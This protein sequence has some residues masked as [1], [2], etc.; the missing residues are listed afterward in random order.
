MKP[1]FLQQ[2]EIG[3][4]LTPFIDV[5]FL[6]I[7]FF[8]LVFQF[9]AAEL[10]EVRLPEKIASVDES[11]ARAMVTITV[12]QNDGKVSYAAGSD[13]LPGDE[14]QLLERMVASA[15]DSREIKDGQEKIVCL[16]CD[17]QVPFARVRPVLDGIAK[18]SAEKVQWATL[19]D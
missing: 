2:L 12:M 11:A 19:K 6:L 16:R 9:F 17:K 3:F 5:I 14:P 18:S 1:K 10:F 8:M 4:D 7:I 13:I 15:I